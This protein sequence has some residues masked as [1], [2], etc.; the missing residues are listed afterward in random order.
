MQLSNLTRLVELSIFSAFD[1]PADGYGVL[2]GIASLRRLCL[3]GCAHCPA[4]LG[5]LSQITA[6]FLDK[7]PYKGTAA[8]QLQQTEAILA[9]L[10][11]LRHLALCPQHITTPFPAP[12][13]GMV[14]LTALAWVPK[15]YSA[16]P[17]P[18][19]PFPELPPGGYLPSLRRLVV[20]AAL[21]APSLGVLSAGAS[22][23]ESLALFYFADAPVTGQQALMHWAAAH[24][25]LRQL[26]LEMSGRHLCS[27]TLFS[28]TGA[29]QRSPTLQLKLEPVKR[30]AWEIL[31][32]A[33]AGLEE[34]WQLPDTW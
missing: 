1:L 12:L 18:W 30:L 2:E 24:P 9:G 28:V 26:S 25:T 14:H 31:Q 7:T 34:P 16:P 22:G 10:S 6:L 8:L 29:L 23:L 3:S 11:Q 4:S 20:P 15:D 19:T 21:A 13:T 5:S 33:P 27:A 32:E 17:Q